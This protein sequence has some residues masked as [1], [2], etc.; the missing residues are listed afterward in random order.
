[1]NIFHYWYS[2]E[3]HEAT[4]KPHTNLL[5]QVE[6]DGDS[7]D[8]IQEIQKKSTDNWAPLFSFLFSRMQSLSATT[9][10]YLDF[11]SFPPVGRMSI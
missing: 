3:I 11:F 8:N 9:G 10:T 1:M 7:N 2:Q 6:Y 5:T 4:P